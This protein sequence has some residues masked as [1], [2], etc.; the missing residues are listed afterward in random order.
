M[1]KQKRYRDADMR[2]WTK[3][4]YFEM[5]NNMGCLANCGNSINIDDDWELAHVKAF[6]NDGVNIIQNLVPTCRNCNRQCG[7]K[8]LIDYMKDKGYDTNIKWS[9]DT[10]IGYIVFPKKIYNDHMILAAFEYDV[11][12]I[13]QKLNS[14]SNDDIEWVAQLNGL[15]IKNKKELRSRLAYM[16]NSGIP[17]KE[18]LRKR[19]IN[20]DMNKFPEIQKE[21]KKQTTSKQMNDGKKL[22]NYCIEN[23]YKAL[24]GLGGLAIVTSFVGKSTLLD[25]AMDIGLSYCK[26]VENSV[27]YYNV[28]RK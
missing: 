24:V 13:I 28:L 15:L 11:S 12:K 27:D 3:K 14:L 18:W 26:G 7:D 21:I 9:Y 16:M 4:Y 19:Y 1:T 17:K 23:P 6:A 5:S 2:K 25:G 20:D 8:H 22:A 10:R